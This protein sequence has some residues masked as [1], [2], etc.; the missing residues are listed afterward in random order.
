[1]FSMPATDLAT[2]PFGAHRAIDPPGCLPYAARRLDSSLPLRDGEA[3]IAVEALNIDS[4]SFTQLLGEAEG[5]TGRVAGRVREIVAERGKMHNP[6]TGS[7]GV[8]IGTVAEVAGR[9]APRVGDRIVTLASL[10]TTPLRLD[11]VTEVDPRTHQIKAS[12][13]AILFERSP[14]AILDGSLPEK[15]AMSVLDVCGAPAQAQRLARPGEIVV[16]VGAAGKSGLLVSFVAARQGA[17]VVGIV[18][19]D[20][21]AARL[22]RL[23][24]IDSVFAVDATDPMAVHRAVHAATGGAMADVV[25]NCVNVPDTEMSCILAAR[26]RGL[27]YFFSM[28]TRFQAAALGAEAV[29]A[30]VD[31]MIGNGYAQGHAELALGTVRD[32]PVLREIF[33]EML[34]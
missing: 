5:D 21:E 2:S 31:L 12:G 26:P 30:D 33:E 16:V 27:V 24:G 25:F 18:R 15:L 11:S 9:R 17:R 8:L 28:A 10:T 20:H 6:V 22:R 34:G 1:M 3:L 19:D 23:P 7:G 32:N 4:A 14:Y 13:Q 29:G